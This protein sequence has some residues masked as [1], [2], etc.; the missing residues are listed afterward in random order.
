MTHNDRVLTA[1]RAG[2]CTASELYSLGLIA[3]SRV[4]SL[5]AKGHQISCTRVPGARRGAL[6]YLYTLESEAPLGGAT[7]KPVEAIPYAS[8]VDGRVVP[9]SG[10]DP[11]WGAAPVA[12]PPLDSQLS[13]F[14]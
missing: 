10:G 9:P 14:G 2:P 3:H 8:R 4:A 1:L 11:P 6:T 13:V 7:R 5:R 12:T